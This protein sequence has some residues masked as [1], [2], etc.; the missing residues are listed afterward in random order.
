V[1]TIK[2]AHLASF[3]RL[4]DSDVVIKRTAAADLLTH[5]TGVRGALQTSRRVVTTTR[6]QYATPADTYRLGRSACC[7]TWQ[8][9]QAT[10]PASRQ[11][12]SR[13]QLLH[14]VW[15]NIQL[16]RALH[17]VVLR[18]MQSWYC[19]A[20]ANNVKLLYTVLWWGGG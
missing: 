13:S 18:P 5:C 1:K 2:Q 15:S 6:R 8:A 10:K 3:R 9:V 12:W 20:T 7:S 4:R 16:H 19:T 14:R 17:A 11:V